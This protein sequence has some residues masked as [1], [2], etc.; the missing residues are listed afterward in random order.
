MPPVIR[1]ATTAADFAANA[2]LLA[3][4]QIWDTA[5]SLAAGIPADLIAS[6]CYGAEAAA[7]ETGF[8]APGAALLLAE[9]QGQVSAASAFAR[10]RP[11]WPK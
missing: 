1:T 10:C 11:A 5:K 6:A 2:R 4:M 9:D 7:P 8:A 3:A